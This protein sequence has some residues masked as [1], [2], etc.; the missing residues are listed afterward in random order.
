MNGWGSQ[1]SPYDI[2][3]CTL[4]QEVGDQGYAVVDGCPVQCSDVFLIPLVYIHPIL[5]NQLSTPEEQ[6]G[7]VVTDRYDTDH[8]WA[9][10]VVFE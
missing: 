1:L 8:V 6:E 2:D 4:L 9:K 7:G 5:L 10:K 3:I